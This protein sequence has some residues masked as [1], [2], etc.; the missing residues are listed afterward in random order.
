MANTKILIATNEST[1]A[2]EL[3]KCLITLG[4]KIS[5]IAASNEEILAKIE[6]SKPDLIL[7]DIRLNEGSTG[8]NTAEMIRSTYN[9]PN[10]YLTGTGG[11][12]TIQRAKSTGPFGYIF[13]PLD[14]KQIYA[15]IET[16]L[17]RHLL[18][19]ELREDRRWLNAVLDGIND[20]VIAADNQNVVRFINP[21]AEQLT[22]WSEIETIEKTVNEVFTI[23]DENTH[24]RVEIFGIENSLDK[25]KANTRFE[26][27]L[28]SKSGKITP[29]E[30][31]L[32]YLNDEKGMMAGMVLVFRDISKHREDIQEIQRQSHRAEVLVETA[33]RLNAQL[34][35]TSVLV[36]ICTI[37][38]QALRASA[39]AVFLHN[40]RQDVFNIMATSTQITDL[41]KYDGIQFEIPGIIFESILSENKP[42]VLLSDV[43][44]NP[45]LPY[46]EL[47]H[48][49]NIQKISVAGL[50]RR[51][52]LIG[53]LIS[54]YIGDSTHFLEDTLALLKGLANQAAISITNASLFDQVQKGREHQKILTTRLVEIQETERRH[55]ARELHD[56]IGQV[57]TGLQ[58][59]LES[60]KHQSGE[61]HLNKLNEAQETVGGLIEQIREMSLNLRPPMLD[62]IGLIPTLLWHFERYTKQTNIEVL[63]HPNGITQRLLPDLETAVYR[64]VQEALTNVA[65]HAKVAEVSVQLTRREDILEVKITDQGIGFNS[66]ADPA[67]WSTAGLAGMRERANLLGGY[68]MVQSALHTGTQILAMLPLNHKAMERRNRGRNDN[69]S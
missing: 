63:F 34:N 12:A 25:K 49:Q 9:I 28:I 47:F 19:A 11:Q 57:L 30:A 15:T 65:R 67:K 39:T 32:T 62:D 41:K 66:N 21:V 27:L 7:I 20:G 48:E 37:S 42:V 56:Q 4:Y 52:E 58:F 16:A 2:Q 10:I 45:N 23:F 31:D 33:A 61:K 69:T 1:I 3:S 22:S 36:T 55:L 35:L 38:N 46:L 13:K 53:V 64:I 8:I 51:H 43:Q 59:M 29:V 50:Y 68:L 60:S 6:E 26:G 40:V 17:L 5:G 44:N 18:E 14:E 54:I 24:E